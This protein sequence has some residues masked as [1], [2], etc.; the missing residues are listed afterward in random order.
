MCNFKSFDLCKSPARFL[1]LTI[2]KKE[3]NSQN[4]KSNKYFLD[5]LSKKHKIFK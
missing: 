1:Y 4:K 2:K 5:F 3:A